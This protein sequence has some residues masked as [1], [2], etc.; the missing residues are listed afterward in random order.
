METV[1]RLI[2]RPSASTGS[3]GCDRATRGLAAA[4]AVATACDFADMSCDVG[5]LRAQGNAI[6]ADD[7]VARFAPRHLGD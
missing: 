4:G 3:C 6:A 2:G 5:R 7:R 1:A